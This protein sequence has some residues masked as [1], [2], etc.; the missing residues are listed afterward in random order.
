MQLLWSRCINTRGF[1]GSNIPC[2]LFMEHLN[3]RLKT[4][5]RNLGANITPQAIQ[6]A[7]KTIAPVQHI[8]RVF[9]QQTATQSVSGHHSIP[10][11]S[12]DFNMILKL[13]TDEKVLMPIKVREHSTYK[14]SHTIIEKHSATELKKKVETS[15]KQLYYV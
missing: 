6:K 11:F 5:L 2:D 1:Q 9:E 12:K 8:C 15:L 7:G 4:I 10:S 14:H 13:I 3:R